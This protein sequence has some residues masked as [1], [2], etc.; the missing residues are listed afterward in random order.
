MN[1]KVTKDALKIEEMSAEEKTETR[2]PNGESYCDE[3]TARKIL[4]KTNA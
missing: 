4:W 1:D 3:Q 2:F